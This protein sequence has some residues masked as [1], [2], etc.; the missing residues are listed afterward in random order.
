MLGLGDRVVCS[1]SPNRNKALSS[2]FLHVAP[3]HLTDAR[4]DMNTDFFYLICYDFRKINDRI[5]IF[6]DKCTSSVVAHGVRLLPPLLTALSPC[7]RGTRRQESISCASAGSMAPGPCRR[8][9]RRQRLNTVP[10]DGR[11]FLVF[12][13][14]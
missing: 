2:S 5:K 14:F 3:V 7:R 4:A 1:R 6:F 8:A 11:I 10:H 13:F 9:A 12:D